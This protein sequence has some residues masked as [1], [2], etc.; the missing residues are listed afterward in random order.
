MH[1]YHV[2]FYEL[3]E[4]FFLL[5]LLEMQSISLLKPPADV[6]KNLSKRP[7]ESGLSFWF[8]RT[9]ALRFLLE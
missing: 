3:F 9:E 5:N 6:D 2:L 8:K 7:P 4:P 1:Y